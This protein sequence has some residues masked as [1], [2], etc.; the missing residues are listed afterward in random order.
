MQMS[1]SLEKKGNKITC[2]RC[3]HLWNYGGTNEY[4]AI[5]PHCRTTVSLRRQTKTAPKELIV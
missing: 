4:V 5:C 1:L 3:K 2:H